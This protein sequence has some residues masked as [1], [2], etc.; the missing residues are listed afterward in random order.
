[1][2]RERV[3][4]LLQAMADNTKTLADGVAKQNGFEKAIDIPYGQKEYAILLLNRW[5]FTLDIL[6]ILTDA[7]YAEDIYK[8]YLPEDK[9][10]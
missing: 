2:K 9:T 1:M 3:L 10:K 4:K 6:R 8:I 7:E 5:S